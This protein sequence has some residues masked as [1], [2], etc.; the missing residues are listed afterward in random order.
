MCHFIITEI[1]STNLSKTLIIITKT[2]VKPEN[3]KMLFPLPDI[4]AESPV[5]EKQQKN[6]YNKNEGKKLKEIGF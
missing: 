1:Y 5:M 6:N 3:V 2:L 4:S